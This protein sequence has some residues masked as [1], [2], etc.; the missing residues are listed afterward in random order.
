MKDAIKNLRDTLA[1][2][3][4]SSNR[5][6]QTRTLSRIGTIVSALNK[7]TSDL[8]SCLLFAMYNY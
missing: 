7:L 1:G 8:Y 6:N 2:L 4:C 5:N 3:A